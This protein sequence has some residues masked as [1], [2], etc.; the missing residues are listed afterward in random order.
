M[1]CSIGYVQAMDVIRHNCTD[2]FSKADIEEN[3]EPTELDATG[4]VVCATT[5]DNYVL[6]VKQEPPE[7]ILAEIL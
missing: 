7:V 2:S 6:L 1:C 5:E 4:Y 3:F